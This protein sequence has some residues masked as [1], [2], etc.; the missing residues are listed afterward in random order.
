AVI[1]DLTNG[2]PVW[3]STDDGY[4]AAAVATSLGAVEAGRVGAG[5]GATVAKLGD[6]SRAGGLGI[7]SVTT[8]PT[9]VTA[10]VVVN[11]V[12]DIVDPATGAALAAAIDPVGSGRNGRE[13]AIDHAGEARVGENTSIGVVLIDGATDRDTLERCCVAA[14]DGLARCVVPAHTIF[15]GDTFFAVAR[16]EQRSSPS[17]TLSLTSATEM[18][19]EHAIVSIFA[20]RS[21]D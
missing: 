4:R 5:A 12:G 15:D 19:V 2:A 11:A 21:S 3:P 1:F 6:G 13:M 18:A 9:T 16:R 20:G 14:H 10:L 7:A 8:G 17:E